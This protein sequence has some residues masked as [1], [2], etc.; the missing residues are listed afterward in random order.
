[1]QYQ[2]SLNY[3]L[4]K[5]LKAG[6]DTKDGNRL[7]ISSFASLAS[8]ASLMSFVSLLCIPSLHPQQDRPV[9]RQFSRELVRRVEV[10]AQPEIARD[11]PT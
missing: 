3:G 1:M 2:N 11:R 7:S 6:N 10:F 5:D 8:L 4:K 9:G